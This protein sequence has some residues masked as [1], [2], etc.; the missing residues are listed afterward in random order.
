[1]SSKKKSGGGGLLAGFLGNDPLKQR[2]EKKAIYD[3]SK[4]CSSCGKKLKPKHFQ[5]KCEFTNY[6]DPNCQRSHWKAHKANHKALMKINPYETITFNV[7]DLAMYR[8]EKK[9]K[10]KGTKEVVIIME[11][12][13]EGVPA[14]V[15]QYT[16]MVLDSQYDTKRHH[17]TYQ[18]PQGSK[19][20]YLYNRPETTQRMLFE[21]CANNRPEVV[22]A[23]VNQR[24]I[25]LNMQ[26]DQHENRPSALHVATWANDVEIVQLLVDQPSIKLNLQTK[27]GA[28]PLYIACHSGHFDIVEILCKQ[29]GKIDINMMQYN[30]C[31]PLFCAADLNFSLIV[32]HL[33]A[34]PACKVNLVNK[35]GR[36]PLIQASYRGLGEDGST[37]EDVIRY[38]LAH[39]DIDVTPTVGGCTAFQWAQ[40]QNHE[41]VLVEFYRKL[42]DTSSVEKKKAGKKEEQP[43]VSLGDL[44]KA[45]PEFEL[46]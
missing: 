21:S 26:H 6:C 40:R 44:V 24:D 46:D 42:E 36:T 16:I 15:T 31:T 13:S 2:Q 11:L 9:K 23:L 25:N 32:K 30:G 39:K 12:H 7:G 38:L 28:T 17:N 18:V 45:L 22:A 27:E 35:H 43:V 8:L 4:H 10:K 33:L 41:H 19:N 20:L 14:R 5:C 37:N 3:E 29:K 1:M 34:L